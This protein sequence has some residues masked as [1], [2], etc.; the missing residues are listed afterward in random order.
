MPTPED[1]DDTI[2]VEAPPRTT[3]KV[4]LPPE[5]VLERSTFNR[6]KLGVP[7]LGDAYEEL[8]GSA[9]ITQH[10]DKTKRFHSCAPLN[11]RAAADY[12][13]TDLWCWHC[14]HPFDTC[15]VPIPRTYDTRDRLYVVYGCFCSL[16]CAKAF[17]LAHAAFDQT[18]QLVLLERMG[19]E[20]FGIDHV[21]T[22]AP[23]RTLLDVFGGPYSLARFRSIGTAA[24]ARLV[25]PPFVSSYMCAEERELETTRA[26]ALGVATGIGTVRGLRRPAQ[27]VRLTSA[28]AAA[29]PPDPDAPYLRF[30]AQ[31]G[32]ASADAAAPAASHSDASS[33]PQASSAPPSQASERGAAAAAGAAT[34]AATTTHPAPTPK[35][36]SGGGTLARFMR[37]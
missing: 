12:A 30:L 18:S 11:A 10:V 36:G 26:S 19:H 31:K 7:G 29:A 3:S 33:A 8:R 24:R 1:D 34:R 35:A 20:V 27:P 37:R 5:C 22:P 21:V 2:V 25:A 4:A 13:S 9:S 28:D 23:D 6:A 14:C 17:V 16:A 32:V 15:V